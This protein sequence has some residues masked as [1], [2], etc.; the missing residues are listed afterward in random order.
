MDALC[1]YIRMKCR[2][3]NVHLDTYDPDFI[4]GVILEWLE[5]NNAKLTPTG[6][7]IIRYGT[8]TFDQTDR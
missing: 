2:D 3:A 7:E 1:E 4:L 6:L 8:E 5:K